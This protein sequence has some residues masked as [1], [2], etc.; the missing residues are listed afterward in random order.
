M[1]RIWVKLR[2]PY[3]IF[4]H[5]NKLFNKFGELKLFIIGK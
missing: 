1:M 3:E 5:N 4:A 2:V